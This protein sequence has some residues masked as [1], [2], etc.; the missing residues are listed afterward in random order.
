MKISANTSEKE[1]KHMFKIG[2]THPDQ[3]DLEEAEDFA[4]AILDL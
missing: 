4:M 1:L 3:E 2:K